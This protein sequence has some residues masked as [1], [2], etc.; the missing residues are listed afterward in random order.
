MMK[1]SMTVAFLLVVLILATMDAWSESH[2]KPVPRGNAVWTYISETNPYETWDYWP[3]HEGMYPGKSPHGAFLKLYAN[4]MAI[5][6]ARKGE[7]MPSG[8]ILVKENYGK[9]KK[10]LVAITPMYKVLGYNPEN[11]DW[12]WAKYEAN[13]TIAAEGMVDSCIQC[14]LSAKQNDYI[15]T[16]P[17]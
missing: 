2:K 4:K 10:T 1:R 16:K 5:E 15:F 12:F 7:P 6:A 13:G 17:K 8:A 14:H 11:G 9:D 3:G